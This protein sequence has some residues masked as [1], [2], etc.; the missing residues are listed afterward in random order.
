MKRSEA[1]A[2]EV[3]SGGARFC[4]DSTP[5]KT[6]AISVFEPNHCAAV[7]PCFNESAR[8]AALI[9]AVRRQLPAVLV[10]DDGST[11]DTMRLAKGAGAEV[12]RH[13]RNLG[14]G[15]A[16]KTGLAQ[17]LKQGHEWAAT[18]DG[19]GQHAPEDLPA[20]FRCAQATGAVLVIGNR[21]NEARKMAWLRRQANRWMS[22][23]LSRQ[24]GRRLP[25]TQSGLRLIH[26]QTWATLPL[27]TE[28]FEIESETLM[29]FLAAGHRV[30]FA[31]VQVNRSGRKSHIRPVADSWRWL[32]WWWRLGL[33]R[34]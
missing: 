25:D 13:D 23:Q 24:A 28:R 9:P 15:A 30:E 31:A 16:L 3:K 32:K 14:K 19:D 29:A 5:D 33:A 22:W 8:I 17:A 11:D 12:L 18:L 6:Q 21:M 4:L 20:L 1:R 27:K 2:P 7:I 26:L 34:Q 10:V